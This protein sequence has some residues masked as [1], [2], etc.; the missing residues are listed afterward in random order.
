MISI[1]RRRKNRYDFYCL[2]I[3]G[4]NNYGYA[5]IFA[6]AFTNIKCYESYSWIFNHFIKRSKIANIPTKP[7]LLVCPL[8]QEIIDC[9]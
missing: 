1:S 4:I 8:E 5:V 9:A 2:L 3:S 6:I 7:D